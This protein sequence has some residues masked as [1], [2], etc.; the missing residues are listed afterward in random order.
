M[1]IPA[2]NSRLILENYLAFSIIQVKKTYL[3]HL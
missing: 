1:Q 2:S 3:N